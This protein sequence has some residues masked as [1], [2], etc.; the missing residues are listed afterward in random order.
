MVSSTNAAYYL[1]VNNAASDHYVL[2]VMTVVAV[3]F[4][5]IVLL[6]QC[7]SFHIFRGRI[8]EPKPAANEPTAET[9]PAAAPTQTERQARSRAILPCATATACYATERCGVEG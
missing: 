9:D 4:F 1:T 8:S 3:L 2:V 6:Y 5:P 7:W